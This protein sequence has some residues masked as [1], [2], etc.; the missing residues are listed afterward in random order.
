MFTENLENRHRSNSF[1]RLFGSY[2]ST[3]KIIRRAAQVRFWLVL[4]ARPV[5]ITTAHSL[6]VSSA[7]VR[8]ISA[9]FSS[10]RYKTEQSQA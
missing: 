4:K 2:S 8:Y 5:G 10:I 7:P 3:K 6:K 9:K 1:I